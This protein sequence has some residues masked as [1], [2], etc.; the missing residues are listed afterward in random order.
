MFAFQ[1]STKIKT[2]QTQEIEV[3]CSPNF[4][5]AFS[6]S[7]KTTFRESRNMW[8]GAPRQRT[9]PLTPTSKIQCY[10]LRT[11]ADLASQAQGIFTKTVGDLTHIFASPLVKTGSNLPT[12][13][14]PV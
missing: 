4:L 1:E 6:C 3:H 9:L 2:L 12:P 8:A 10:G 5:P 14:Q 13:Y 7:A 11:H